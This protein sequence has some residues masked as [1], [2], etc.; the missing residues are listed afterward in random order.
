MIYDTELLY[1]RIIGLQQSRELDI[2]DIL[3]YEPSA[4][5]SALFDEYG[6]M[7]SSSK[8]IL[9]NKLHIEVSKRRTSTYDALI[10]D[11]CALLWII[12]W[13]AT[14][15]V[16]Q[17][18]KN[19]ITRLNDYLKR[20]CVYLIFDRYLTRSTKSATRSNHAGMNLSRRHVLKL[21]TPLPSKDVILK[22]THKTQ[23]IKLIVQY[24]LDHLEDN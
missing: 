3:A 8:A 11:G 12:H 6:N 4:V 17:Y 1:S 18:I 9:K 20:C 5:P 10:I 19:L 2:R 23:L 16:E 14:G 15:T 13:P 22:V 24:L 21:Q 7:R